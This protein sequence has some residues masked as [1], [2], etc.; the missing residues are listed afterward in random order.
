MCIYLRHW[1]NGFDGGDLFCI[2]ICSV[3]HIYMYIVYLIYVF[4]LVK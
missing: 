1:V 3:T 4:I 2:F